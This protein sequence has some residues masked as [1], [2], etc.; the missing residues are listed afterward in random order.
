MPGTPLN[1]M[2]GVVHVS[3]R[4]RQAALRRA[5]AEA[6]ARASRGPPQTI[7][8]SNDDM[9]GLVRSL[10]ALDWGRCKQKCTSSKDMDS[11]C[12]LQTF[13]E[14]QMAVYD[15]DG[16]GYLD[17]KEL[18]NLMKDLNDGEAQFVCCLT[19]LLAVNA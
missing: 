18:A 11:Y 8:L 6:A 14:E 9:V 13:L 7:Q 15:K 16:N 1:G 19:A 17:Q 10:L 5:E 4:R 3:A 12:H 2:I